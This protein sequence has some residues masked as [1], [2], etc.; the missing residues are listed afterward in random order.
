MVVMVVMPLFSVLMV[1]MM[2]MVVALFC[3]SS[4]WQQNRAGSA[5]RELRRA[6]ERWECARRGGT[7]PPLIIAETIFCCPITA[8]WHVFPGNGWVTVPV[9]RQTDSRVRRKSDA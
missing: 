6:L 8:C 7:R 1:V 3:F 2:V 9:C 5:W 4:A